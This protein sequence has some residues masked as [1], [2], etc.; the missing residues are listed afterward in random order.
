MAKSKLTKKDKKRIY[1]LLDEDNFPQKKVAELY[2]ISQGTVSS[3]KKEMAYETKIRNLEN[4]QENA[5]VRGVQAAI[6]DGQFPVSS[7]EFIE[8]K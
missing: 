2:G 6:E 1:Q 7:I 4:Q 8:S 3:V 5:M